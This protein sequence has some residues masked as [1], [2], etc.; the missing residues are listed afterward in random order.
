MGNKPIE[1]IYRESDN[2]WWV[3]GYTSDGMS[4]HVFESDQLSALQKVKAI[5]EEW[6]NFINLPILTQLQSS[7][8][9]DKTWNSRVI[10]LIIDKLVD[11]EKRLEE[12]KLS[13]SP[14][15]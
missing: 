5:M 7:A 10:K 8:E 3:I 6:E 12:L 4:H 15:K 11:H 9:A 14:E 13:I 1:Q 2:T